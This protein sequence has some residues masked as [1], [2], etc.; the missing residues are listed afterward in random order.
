MFVSY[1]KYKNL[2]NAY[3]YLVEDRQKQESEHLEIIKSLC[4]KHSI[5]L[6]EIEKINSELEK[7]K[8]L[9]ADELQKRLELTKLVDK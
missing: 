1:K 9:Y 4:D 5:A 8:K 7:Y 2:Q 6:K 3:N